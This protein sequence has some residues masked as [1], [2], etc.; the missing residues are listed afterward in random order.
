MH[1]HTYVLSGFVVYEIYNN[2][3]NQPNAVGVA[4]IKKKKFCFKYKYV[5]WR[6]DRYILK[7]LVAIVLLFQ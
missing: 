4:N 1:I 5:I 2:R 6:L 3:I 7:N